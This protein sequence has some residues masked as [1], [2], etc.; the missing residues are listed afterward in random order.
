[1][2]IQAPQ[3]FEDLNK[4][5]LQ[6]LRIMIVDDEPT[7]CD[8]LQLYFE[9][10][11]VLHTDTANDGG[12]ALDLL[13]E[14][15]YDFVF[16][17]IML[18]GISGLD[19]LKT[20]R[21]WQKVVNVI[22]M[23]G[24]PS[25]EIAIDAMHSGASDFLVKPFGFQDIKITLSRIQ[26]LRS[27]MKKNWELHQEL[28]K[29]KEVEELNIQLE[30]RIKQ[31]TL[32]Y[33]IIDSLS[34][35]S[36]SDDI[37]KFIVQQAAASAGASR[38]C[39]LYYDEENSSMMVLAHLGLQGLQTGTQARVLKK[40]KGHPLLDPHFLHAHFGSS[41]GS[42]I[43]L[44]RI[45]FTDHMMG[46]PFKIRTE[47]FGLL[48]VSDK[49]DAS[50]FDKEDRFILDFLAEKTAISIENIA[51]YDNLKQNFI[52]SL[53]S[54]VSAIEAKDAYTQQHSERV[55]S[56]AI[57]I[58]AKMA[59]S[60]E[61]LEQLNSSG[62]LHDIGKIGIQDSILNKPGR[63]DDWEFEQIRSHPL[64]GVNIVS[65]L[66]LSESELSIIRN[67][68]ERWDGRGYPDGLKAEETPLIARILAVADSFDAMSS[69]RAYR[70]ALPLDVC[71]D[72]LRK[73]SGTQ[74]DPR[75]VE[76]ALPVLGS[77]DSVSH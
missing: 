5:D 75:V 11:G 41:N 13:G 18:P 4:E 62:P 66:G 39:F 32:L 27:L 76:A 30:K 64:I 22:L 68:H 51:L 34:K 17:D 47:L 21:E 24:Y 59:C 40:P 15:D 3:E 54:L 28:A 53:L 50:S 35:I 44:D 60:Q 65:P 26:R 49:T 6:S 19:V 1:M 16:L 25:M 69:N 73:N 42:E 36:R 48:L 14:N 37:Y 10:L 61:E 58:A 45:T 43:P 12:S 20:L 55:T 46:I 33:R 52:A 57:Q 8:T 71:L 74:F 67:H 72:E 23:T 9:H 70:N 63:L 2:Q 29:K 56:Y 31:Q 38:S 77:L 7:I